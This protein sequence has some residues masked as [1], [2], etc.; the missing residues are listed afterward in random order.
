MDNQILEK[1]E[2]MR[3]NIVGQGNDKNEFDGI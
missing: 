2:I 3:F 1:G